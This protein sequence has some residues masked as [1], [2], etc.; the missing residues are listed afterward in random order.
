MKNSVVKYRQPSLISLFD[1]FIVPTDVLLDRAFSQLIPEWN[2]T[3]GNVFEKAAYPKIDLRETENSYII[4]AETPG[5]TKDHLKVE[6]KD[7]LLVIR[8][9]KR[10]ETKKEGVYHLQE[11]KRSSFVRTWPLSKTLV[12]KNSIKAK[13]V[14]G[15]LEIVVAKLK[16][17]PP[18]EPP[19]PEIVEVK[20]D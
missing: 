4:E 12:D 2:S 18:P 3:F 5:L 1:D 15:I 7:D 6:I 9:E 10:E 19:K 17:T 16:P 8:G 13:F 14:N 20:I 11:I